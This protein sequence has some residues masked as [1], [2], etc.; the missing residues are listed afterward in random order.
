MDGYAYA[1]VLKN[2]KRRCLMVNTK[3]INMRY[4]KPANITNLRARRQEVLQPFIPE[5][6]HPKLKA[7]GNVFTQRNV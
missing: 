7:S 5:I 6:S 4:S 3:C 2:L 1:F